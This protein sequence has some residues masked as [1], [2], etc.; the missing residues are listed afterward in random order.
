MKLPLDQ[1]KDD[2]VNVRKIIDNRELREL[3]NSIEKDGV[4]QPITVR[5]VGNTYYATAGKLRVRAARILEMDTIPVELI[6][7][8][9][10]DA[11][12][13]SFKENENRSNLTIKEKCDAINKMIKDWGSGDKV[14]E[15]TGIPKHKI[16]EYAGIQRL[17]KD[18]K[19]RPP[20]SKDKSLGISESTAISLSR[21]KDKEVQKKLIE[22]I[23]DKPTEEAIERIEEVK[24]GTVEYHPLEED[25]A[26]FLELGPEETRLLNIYCEER[27]LSSGEAIRE[28]IREYV[29]LWARQFKKV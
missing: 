18:I 29:P 13:I 25:N 26:M 23:E 16:Y 12:I 5:K 3:V 24:S 19:I 21:V 28:I 17:D 2:P 11:R 1:I 8:N 14:A 9:D 15:R 4:V 6:E 7:A 20:H 27:H 10:K 22:E